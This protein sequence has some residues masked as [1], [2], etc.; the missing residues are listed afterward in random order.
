MAKLMEVAEIN[1]SNL[2]DVS[3][4]RNKIETVLNKAVSISP[5]A[6][7]YLILDN[8]GKAIAQYIQVKAGDLTK[9]SALPTS[10]TTQAIQYQPVSLPQAIHLSD[11]PMVANALKTNLPLAGT[12]LL[13]ASVMQRLGLEQQASIGLRQQTIVSIP[14]S[15]QPF[16]EGIFDIDTG[17]VG[18][19]T[20]AVVPIQM[21]TQVVGVAVVGTLINQN[22]EIVDR[23]RQKTGVETATIFALDWRVSTN[24]PYMDH[25]TR[26]I[27][28][29]V[30]R[31]VADA[32]LNRQTRFIGESNIVGQTYRTAY[33]PIYNHRKAIDPGTKPIGIAYVGQSQQLIQKNL[34]SFALT[35]YGVGGT[36]LFLAG[37]VVSPVARSFSQALYRLAFLLKK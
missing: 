31:E 25:K 22:F 35:S 8:Q 21:N 18:L 28:T 26:A 19:A 3:V 7:W 16:P 34:M 6:S 2:N 24:I 29:R 10:R 14:E 20:M 36:I 12:E 30:A 27:G 37:F 33:S 1:V 9:Y 32:V 15:Q 17:K 11:L 23:L 13:S 5:D 4:G